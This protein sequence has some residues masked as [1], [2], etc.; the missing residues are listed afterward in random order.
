MGQVFK[1]AQESKYHREIYSWET[2][3]EHW[4]QYLCPWIQ[5]LLSYYLLDILMLILKIFLSILF[6]LFFFSLTDIF[7]HQDT[8]SSYDPLFT[9]DLSPSFFFLHSYFMLYKQRILKKTKLKKRNIRQLVLWNLKKSYWKIIMVNG[10]STV[11]KL[12]TVLHKWA[13]LNLLLLMGGNKDG[14]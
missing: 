11:I 5:S 1:P 3:S 14:Q 4:T 8:I 13:L 10:L 2:K 9:K 6:V 7:W 12:K